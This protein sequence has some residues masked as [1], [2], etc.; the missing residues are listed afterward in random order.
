MVPECLTPLWGRDLSLPSKSCGYCSPDRRCFKTLSWG[1]TIFTSHQVKQ[2]LNGRGHLWMSDQRILRYQVVLMENP[3]LYPRVRFFP[4]CP[5]SLLPRNFGLLDKTPRGI[6]KRSSDQS[7][8]SLVHWWK[9]L[10]HECKK[11]SWVYS[12]LKCWDPIEAK[13]LPQGTSA[14]LAELR[15]LAPALELGKVAIYTDSKYA[16]LVLHAHAAIWKERGHLTTRGFPVKY[17]DQMLRLLEA[18]HLLLRFQSPTVRHTKKGAWK[19]H[20]G[21]NQQIKQLR[22]QRCRTILFHLQV[23][24][25]AWK[26]SVISDK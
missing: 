24:K 19:W 11:K 16:F 6:V 3:G 12:S 13:L 21:T 10:C 23:I 1:Q 22:E 5:P 18:V 26:Y 9:Q 14:Q 20:E 15:A 17:A 7:W 25:T 2:P 8:G 4:S